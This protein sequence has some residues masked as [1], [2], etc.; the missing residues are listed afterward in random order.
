[1][2]PVAEEQE[3]CSD[4]KRKH[5]KKIAPHECPVPTRAKV[6]A[7]NKVS[8]LKEDRLCDSAKEDHGPEAFAPECL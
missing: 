1:M 4:E 6:R 7:S 5:R 2:Q 8:G 3:Q